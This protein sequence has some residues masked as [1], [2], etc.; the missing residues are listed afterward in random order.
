MAFTVV[1][2]Y[3]LA[4]PLSALSIEGSSRFVTSTAAPIAT[5]R[6]ESCRVGLTP[7]ERTDLSTAHWH[8]P[9]PRR[10][11]N[12]AEAKGR[13]VRWSEA[14]SSLTGAV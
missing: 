11:F 3:T 4:E 1:T 9:Q 8:A 5:G 10:D 14:A 13:A 6:S 2:A 7:T 12:A